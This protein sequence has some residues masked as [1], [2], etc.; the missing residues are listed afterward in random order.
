MTKLHLLMV[1][2]CIITVAFTTFNIYQQQRQPLDG[3]DYMQALSLATERILTR[4]DSLRKSEGQGGQGGGE[5]KATTTN[6]DIVKRPRCVDTNTIPPIR[7]EFSHYPD[8]GHQD[9]RDMFIQLEKLYLY[10]INEIQRNFIS[11]YFLLLYFIFLNPFFL[12]L[13]NDKK[14]K[15]RI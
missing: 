11:F 6:V 7:Y 14:R 1:L 8:K 12:F 13:I 5:V 15:A 10:L 2:C 4:I 9:S 3:P